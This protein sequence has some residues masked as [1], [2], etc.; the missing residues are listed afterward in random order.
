MS[1]PAAPTAQ[2]PSAGL[3]W[4]S[5]PRPG[6][7]ERV[8]ELVAG[9]GFFSAEEIAVAGELVEDRLDKGA[10]SDYELLFAEDA[11]GRVVG[12][13]C[14][15]RIAL[16]RASWDLY[17][18]AV[19]AAAQGRGVGRAVLAATERRIAA[20]GGGGIWVETS[21]R[22]QYAPTRAFYERCG[23]R[24]A[25]V[26]EDFYADGDGKVIFARKVAAAP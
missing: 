1:Q 14:F 20:R 18:I 13:S 22:P 23:Y 19:D 16:T 17:W 10:A 2:S 6:D 25:A 5:E 26:L 4:R 12:Y 3:T 8:R 9:T 24:V 7:A 11:A 15:G 21:S